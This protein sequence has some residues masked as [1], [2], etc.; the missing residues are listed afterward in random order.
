MAGP[1]P[2][3]FVP[4][5]SSFCRTGPCASVVVPFFFFL[6]DTTMCIL[7]LLGWFP[8]FR[9]QT[10]IGCCDDQK[11]VSEATWDHRFREHRTEASHALRVSQS[12]KRSDAPRQMYGSSREQELIALGE[13]DVCKWV[14]STGLS[15]QLGMHFVE[16]RFIS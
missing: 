14:M 4:F 11:R 9:T 2:F 12:E 10:Q 8:S 7:C 3:L 6:L 13:Q 5:F 15:E 1:C 16:H